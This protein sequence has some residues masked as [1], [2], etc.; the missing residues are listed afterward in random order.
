M[1]RTLSAFTAAQQKTTAHVTEN[2][3]VS[4]YNRGAE[5][6]LML[7]NKTATSAFTVERK[8]AI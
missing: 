1:K 5:N 6:D 8:I 2:S 4:I 3:N 7:L